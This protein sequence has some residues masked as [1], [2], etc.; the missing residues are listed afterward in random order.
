MVTIFFSD[1]VGFTDISG[2]LEA[3][4]VAD[5]LGRLYDKLDTLS[6]K[7]DI[8]KVETI[9]SF[10]IITIDGQ[11]FVWYSNSPVAFFITLCLH[12]G[13]IYGSH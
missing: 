7:H 6:H 5:M 9:G 13:C 12:R 4:K 2:S 10:N 1:I 11:F 3:R 8:F